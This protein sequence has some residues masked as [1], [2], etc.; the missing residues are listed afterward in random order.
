MGKPHPVALR[1]RAIA[2]LE[3]GHTVIERLTGISRDCHGS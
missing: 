3:E 2:F 1:E